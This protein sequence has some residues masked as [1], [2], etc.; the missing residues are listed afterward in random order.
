VPDSSEKPGKISRIRFSFPVLVMIILTTVFILVIFL[1]SV[2]T[3]EQTNQ[4]LHDTWESEV[5]HN[6][7]HLKSSLQLINQGLLLFDHT[8][9][10]SMKEQFSIF[11]DAYNQ[12]GGDPARMNVTDIKS[13]FSRT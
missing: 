8:F 6:E 13:R 9:D 10:K 7:H 1:M 2:I 12:S 11:L 3:Y 4:H 5:Q